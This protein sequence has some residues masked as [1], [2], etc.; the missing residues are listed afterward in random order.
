[1]NKEAHYVDNEYPNIGTKEHRLIARAFIKDEDGNFAVHHLIRD[2][3]FGS[4]DY[5]ETPGGGV[6]EGET[7]EEACIREC[8]EE[9]GYRVQVIKE[10]GFVDDFYNLIQR[11]NLQHY[12]L[13]E[14][15]S[16]YLGKHF[17][18][19]GDNY[20]KETLW[21]PAS[22]IVAL[23]ESVEDRALAHL[24]RQRELPLWKALASKKE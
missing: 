8:L 9:T 7:L 22:Q 3:L 19:G 14:R 16:P 13:C 21:L 4:F 10:V 20:I 17:V 2:D 18:S 24:V 15:V 6:D 23:Y 1:M 11:E 5:Y 12:F